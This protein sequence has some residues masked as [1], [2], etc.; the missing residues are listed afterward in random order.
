MASPTWV[1]TNGINNLRTMR[2][3]AL[4]F[5][6]ITLTFNQLN[7]QD[8]YRIVSYNVENLFDYENDTLTADDEFTPRGTRAWNYEK[9]QRKLARIAKVIAAIG[10]GQPPF[11]VGL[12][13]IENE[14]VLTDLT[15]R[16]PLKM[17]NYSFVHFNS[18]DRRGIDTG[19]LYQR[20]LFRPFHSEPIAVRFPENPTSTTRDILYV[21]GTFLGSDTLH[22]FV[23]H[24]PSRLGG[25]LESE[26]KRCAAAATLKAKADSISVASSN[27]KIVIMGDF[28]DYPHNRSL[29]EV[30]NAQ[31]PD[32][33][34]LTSNGLYNLMTRFADE[35]NMGTHK[36][37]SEWGVLDHIIVSGALLLSENQ[38]ATTAEGAEIF[39]PDFLLEN[40]EKHLNQK[41]F[42]TYVGFRYNNGFSDHLPIFLNLKYQQK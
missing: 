12:C 18:P 33:A 31:T 16:S 7:A 14:K 8:E 24:F 5:A 25:E 15:R 22:V 9:Y 30:L 2:K 23:C 41:P 6:I 36:H 10:G 11:L 34:N 38:L 37:Q 3:F 40:D 42:R 4:I 27:A 29:R 17:M 21:A 39:R 35:P 1:L 32:S 13:E 28:N 26:H 19:L 20:T